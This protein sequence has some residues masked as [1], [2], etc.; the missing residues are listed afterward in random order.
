MTN[1][2]SINRH[3]LAVLVTNEP[4]V[5]AR[6]V[7]LFSG[8]GYNIESLAVAEVNGGTNLSRITI[9]TRGTDD[10]VDQIMAQL[11]RLVPVHRVVNLSK[12]G[13]WIEHEMALVKVTAH[14]DAR[15]KANRIAEDHKAVA[16]DPDA[17]PLIF[18]MT[19]TPSQIDRF[20][21][22]IKPHG[23]IEVVRTGT[24]GIGADTRT[25]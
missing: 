16:V 1:P 8:R 19:G 11:S 17:T 12:A 20:L 22:K 5:L 13:A 6:V 18:H 7:G 21:D 2:Q 3:C 25:L 24:V 10:I 23:L 4:G 15:A 14:G 9:V